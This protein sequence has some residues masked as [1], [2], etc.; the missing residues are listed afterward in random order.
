MKIYYADCAIQDT[1]GNLTFGML[2]KKSTTSPKLRTR[3]AETRALIP[4]GES[5]AQSMLDSDIPFELGIKDAMHFLQLS[6]DCLHKDRF[7]QVH[8]RMLSSSSCK[9]INALDLWQLKNT[10]GISSRNSICLL[11]LLWLG[12]ARL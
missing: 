1:I 6:Y 9:H 8:F 10:L 5:I 4:F 11:R 3:A 7:D 2:R 12:T